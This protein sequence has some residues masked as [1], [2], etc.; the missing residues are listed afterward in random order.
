MSPFLLDS[1][2]REINYL[3]VSVTD[4]C[5]LRCAY[6]MPE[7]GVA[8]LDHAD[9]LRFEEITRVVRVGVGLGIRHVRLT[10]GEPLVRKN[11]VELVRQIRAIPDIESISM[12]TNGI[13]LAQLA[14]AL[15][16]A[17]LD[18]VNV[19]LDSLQPERYR[20][21]TRRGRLNDVLAGI[22]AAFDAGLTPV[23]IN[24]VVMQGVNDDEVVAFARRTLTEIWNVRFIEFMPLG[25]QAVL[26][27]S[28]YVS[29]AVTRRRIENALGALE[30]ADVAGAGPA[31]TWRVP[32]AAGTI[33][34]IS[35]LSEHFCEACNRMRLSSDGKLVPCLFSDTE[36]DL[37]GPLRA[38]AN[39]DSL[40]AIWQEALS[41]KPA[42]HHLDGAI[43]TTEH[44]MSRIG[45]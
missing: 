34:F 29:S 3:R 11:I 17:G 6:C 30:P 31:R 26:A 20:T 36:Y 39:D 43:T 15:R 10:G 1:Y 44:R 7:E 28:E 5:N 9:V 13:A 14:D 32:D 33:G 40:R 41:N 2:D 45:G 25:D 22:D 18:R 4:R 37:R 24:V 42:C 38:G 23:K 16:Q 35:A 21:I 27:R 12:T 19:S 8:T